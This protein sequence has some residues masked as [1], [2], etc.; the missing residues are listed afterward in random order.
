M[1]TKVH[2][3]N[4]NLDFEY[5]VNLALA[6]KLS[7]DSLIVIL[8]DWTPT[9]TKS[10]EVIEILVK[11]LQKRQTYFQEPE[12][13]VP[14]EEIDSNVPQALSELSNP[15]E[16]DADAKEWQ[17]DHENSDDEKINNDIIEVSQE[18]LNKCNFCEKDFTH[19]SR[20]MIHERIHNGEKPFQCKTCNM[21]FAHSST[22][23]I[24]KRIHNGN[25][26]YQCT[27]C[28]KC[29]TKKSDLNRHKT[30]HSGEKS[31]KCETCER[32][33]SQLTHLKRHQTIHTKEKSFQCQICYKC[34]QHLSEM[35][36][37]ESL[38]YVGKP[39]Q[40]KTCNIGFKTSFHLKSHEII[41]TGEKPFQ[42]DIC[43]K[44]FNRSDTLHRHHR[45]V[46][47]RQSKSNC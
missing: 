23:T 18:Q 41:H 21:C 24:H 42:C 14:N 39:F 22:L 19:I 32:R 36:Q 46:H 12:K 17:D 45:D 34:F 7:W 37:H 27:T 6:N 26:P 8:N 40:C 5:F 15:M 31:Y 3:S 25:R 28:S 20:L 44:C 30:V 16:S 13:L 11:E 38:H 1:L 33:Y 4:K 2:S 10:K 29:F 43:N 35:K 47:S 9:L